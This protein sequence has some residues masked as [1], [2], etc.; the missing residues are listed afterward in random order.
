[1]ADA[2]RPDCSNNQCSWNLWNVDH[3]DDFYN[4]WYQKRKLVFYPDRGDPIG[5]FIQSIIRPGKTK[6]VSPAIEIGQRYLMS[7]VFFER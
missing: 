3:T 7:L 6:Q 4:H 5:R 1:M 2:D